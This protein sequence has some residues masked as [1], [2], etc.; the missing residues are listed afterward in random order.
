MFST[1]AVTSIAAPAREK[2]AT[3]VAAKYPFCNRRKSI[4]SCCWATHAHSPCFVFFLIK[5][6]HNLIIILPRCT[7]N[8]TQHCPA[9]FQLGFI[10]LVGFIFE[11][12]VKKESIV[13]RVSGMSNNNKSGGIL[14]GWTKKKFVFTFWHSGFVC[15]GS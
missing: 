11:I 4:A 15:S 9:F 2:T 14:S 13:C 8:T 12:L 1:G 7:N 10:Q 5:R 3:I 6:F